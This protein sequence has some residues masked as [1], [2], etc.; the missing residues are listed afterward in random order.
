[1]KQ[2]R[3]T[4]KRD[5]EIYELVKCERSAAQIHVTLNVYLLLSQPVRAPS[6]TSNGD[7]EKRKEV[8]KRRVEEVSREEMLATLTCVVLTRNTLAS[9][10]IP[11]PPN[12]FF[13]FLY[14]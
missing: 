3:V 10:F 6:V 13:R 9:R 4:L 7:R 1:M 8:K 11:V 14:P 5:F 12:L 2:R